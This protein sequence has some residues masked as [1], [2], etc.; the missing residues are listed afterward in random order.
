M[1]SRPK[2]L[3]RPQRREKE[4]MTVG[5]S[6]A[7]KDPGKSATRVWL[8]CHQIRK[9]QLRVDEKTKEEKTGMEREW[10]VKLCI[11]GSGSS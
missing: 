4:A 5:E 9:T 6:K 2:A 1:D 7:R 11:D 8:K 3:P 10:K